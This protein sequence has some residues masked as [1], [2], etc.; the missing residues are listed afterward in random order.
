MHTVITTSVFERQAKEAG[1][2]EDEVSEMI[3]FLADNPDAGVI[4]PGTGGAR[5]VRFAGSRR[6]KSGGYRT[7][8]YFAADDVP[9]FLLALVK[10]GDRA[11]ISQ[12]ERSQLARTL[13]KIADAYRASVRA[14]A[15]A[16]KRRSP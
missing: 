9:I 12:A 3:V 14:T 4:I 11:D 10:K 2:S 6:G 15:S 16:R 13:P 1:L 7:I 5:K 8:H